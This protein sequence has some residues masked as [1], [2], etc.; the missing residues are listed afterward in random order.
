[1]LNV[2]VLLVAIAS[3]NQSSADTSGR[4]LYSKEILGDAAWATLTDPEKVSARAI[5]RFRND[6]GQQVMIAIERPQPFSFQGPER[7]VADQDVR[8][9]V[10]AMLKPV[11][12]G[13]KRCGFSPDH[14]ITFIKGKDVL[15]LVSCFTCNDMLVQFNGKSLG[16]GPLVEPAK[17]LIL[18]SF[19]KNEHGSSTL[20]RAVPNEV[21]L[22]INSS[23]SAQ[24]LKTKPFDSFYKWSKNLKWEKAGSLGAEDLH[25]LR[26]RLNVAAFDSFAKIRYRVEPSDIKHA[27]LLRLNS[28]PA[29][30]LL[31]MP[32]VPTLI[33]KF[34]GEFVETFLPLAPSYEEVIK[35]VDGKANKL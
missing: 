2:V 5:T 13:R 31:L 21:L 19:T 33:C 15:Q 26:E 4:V 11:Y 30:E 7:L 6:H 10:S 18:R 16:I 35:Y 22:A 25:E 12:V 34:K 32:D 17:E 23:R 20:A 24:I 9:I 8:G 27:Y 3:Q 28:E 14:V 1:M 29:V